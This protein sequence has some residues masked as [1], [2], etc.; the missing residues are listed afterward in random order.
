MNAPSNPKSSSSPAS[1]SSARSPL[2]LRPRTKV[3]VLA[4]CFV[5]MIAASVWAVLQPVRL[6]P[7]DTSWRASIL[8]PHETNPYVRLQAVSC[9]NEYA[10][11]LNSVAVN[12]TGDSPEVWAVGNVGLV[13]HRAAGQRKW[14][15][16]TINA[17][18]ESAPPK[19]SPSPTPRSTPDKK[20][21]AA[22]PTAT[23]TPIATATATPTP[24]Q[25][26][27]VPYL[28]GLSEA[29]A[30]KIAESQGFLVSAV[31]TNDNQINQQ[32]QSI[33]NQS[34]QQSAPPRQVVVKQSPEPK[35]LAP[36][37]STI[38][39]TLGRAP[40][41]KA[42]LFDKLLPKVYAAELDK[43]PQPQGTSVP[44]LSQEQTRRAL[45][46]A[47]EAKP[48]PLVLSPLDDDLLHVA[49]E[50]GE[51]RIF[52][53]SGRVYKVVTATNWSFITARVFGV[54]AEADSFFLSEF[55]LDGQSVYGKTG[56]ALYKCDFH[57]S[58]KAPFY[59][60]NASSDKSLDL[61]IPGGSL[62]RL[63]LD[64]VN[65]NGS[66]SATIRIVTHGPEAKNLVTAFSNVRSAAFNSNLAVAVGEH[67]TILASTDNGGTWLHETQGPDGAA[68]NHKL[69]ALWYWLLAGLFMV[70]SSVV[71][72][73]PG[74][75]PVAEVSVADWAVTD[76]PLKPGDIDSLNFTPMA[77]G[78]SRFVRNPKTQ[79]PVTIAIEG[80]WGE[81]KSS[82]M[83]LLKG[84]LKKSRYCPVWF[85]AWHHQS[86]EQLL[87]ALLEHIKDQAIPPW[88]HI[89]N[90]IF[91]ARL[92]RSRMGRKWPLLVILAIVF[93]STAAFEIS[94]DGLDEVIQS[95]ANL[96]PFKNYVPGLGERTQNPADSAASAKSAASEL[97][98]SKS[99]DAKPSDSKPAQE[100][101]LRHLGLIASLF[102]LLGAIF[103]IAKT[104]GID[105]S[106]LTD[107]LR[108]ATTIKDIKPDPGIRRQF[109]REFRDFCE[110][111]SWGGRRVI[112]FID[113]L[114]RC[115]PE[116]VVTVLESINFLTTAGDCMIVLG[117][118]QKQVTHAVGLSFKDIAQSQQAY[119]DGC[120]TEQ[121]K[122]IA[123]FKYGELYIKK[124]VNIVAHLPKTTPE[125]RRKVLESR[126]ADARRQE[127]QVKAAAVRGW[128][129][130][131]WEWLSES[132]RLAVKFA[133]IMAM[134]LA[135]V[136]SMLVGYQK[137]AAPTPPQQQVASANTSSTS[138]SSLV[139][140]VKQSNEPALSKPGEAKPLVYD[141]PTAQQAKLKDPEGFTGGSWWSYS[142]SVLLLVIFFGLFGYQ[143]SARTNQD[144]QNSPEFEKSLELWGEYIV[145]LCDTPREIKRA[146]NDL[147]YQA[148][149][150]RMNGPS[151]TRGERLARA[152]R[153]LVTGRKEKD[154]VEARVDEAALPPV[155][156]A[157]LAS[158][159]ADEETR[160]LGT[161]TETTY[162]GI[163]ETMKMLLGMKAKHIEIFGRWIGAPAPEPPDPSGN[164][165]KARGA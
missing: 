39:I 161:A 47:A 49:C 54:T 128:R 115:R 101:N 163:T 127:E 95:P 85:N 103:K 113:D 15:Q 82:V 4:L 109:A 106:K 36:L 62:L 63:F 14:E 18:E 122:A 72:A 137:V 157:A 25:R 138:S 34:A 12:G 116:S 134:L 10:C 73:I 71:V 93:A 69:P 81:G 24:D 2:Y 160:F 159:S 78:L 60:C 28:L 9:V 38:T 114:D 46:P 21:A 20:A 74:V 126:A 37:K 145:G 64:Q 11:R 77:L 98:S 131:L 48:L 111:W 152:L 112:I 66:S 26:A 149:T 99:A 79:P 86:E 57:A 140:E 32:A 75:P 158:L 121:E 130:G 129:M 27:P 33:P 6:D 88:W 43:R 144:A 104:F 50:S 125:Q 165:A 7:K 55:T 53:R 150:R 139:N 153:Q 155:K 119:L 67:G 17:L 110:A 29:E 3:W 8:Y 68:P 136:I 92:L 41:S 89:D 117:M 148:M 164:I 107:N 133:P 97:T 120:N 56:S 76:A 52:G 40:A 108:D 80:E 1:A 90:W 132:G 16:L 65:L 87:A 118:A 147:R 59:S 51:C 13:L 23:P 42:S 58:D 146:L 100:T 124:L 19:P 162:P 142:T 83:S 154:P 84:D 30:R 151:S 156:A 143:L 105:S 31:D 44:H 135:I 123:R 94:R 45:T 91:R 96:I 22:R 61:Q 70:V 102:G 141:P 5:L 35:T